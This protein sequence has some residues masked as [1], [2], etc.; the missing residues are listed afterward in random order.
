[1]KA[2]LRW[3]T[4]LLG[5]LPVFLFL[6]GG[7]P[8]HAAVAIES[9]ETRCGAISAPGQLEM[10]TF[11]GTA[12]DRV[13]I[14]AETASGFLD[15]EILLIDPDFL[16]EVDTF[17]GG[18]L[19]DHI[20]LKSGSYTI[21]VRDNGLDHTGSYCL[22]L[23]NLTAGPV[24]SGEDP[25][26][27]PIASGETRSATIALSDMDA[28][29]FDGEAGDRILIDAEAGSGFLD[30]EILL[31]DPHFLNEA[32]TYPRGDLLDHI[33]LK[34]GTYTILV[35]DH[36]LDHTGSYNITLLNL[37]A[38]PLTSSEDPDGGPIASGETR[39]A[40]IALSDMDAYQFYGEAGD[41]VVIDAETGSGF[42]DTEILLIDPHFLNEVD[43]YPGG[44]LLDHVLLETGTYTILVQDHGLDHTGGY[45]LTLLKLP[46][47][48]SSPGD[49]DGGL[50]IAGNSRTGTITLSDMDTYQFYGEAGDRVMITAVRNSGFLD[51]EILLIDPDGLDETD[52]QPGGDLLDHF[53]Q[54]TGLYSFVI[55]DVGLDHT[56]NYSMT[57][58]KF[59]QDPPPGIYQ[60]EP[61]TACN[62]STDLM[63]TWET[64]SDAT[65]YDVFFGTNVVEPLAQIAV[66]E[67]NSSW[68]VTGLEK[69]TVYYWRVVA[70]TP[71]GDVQGT[72]NWFV[73]KILCDLNHDCRC[74]MQDWLLFGQD[75]G[76]TDCNDPG[77]DPCECDL[78]GDGRCD[79]QDWLLFGRQWGWS[80][81]P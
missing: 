36:G 56:G 32:D 58:N 46:G 29:Q 8:I 19:L 51:T 64:V 63:L 41:R 47:A 14:D 79:M 71:G 39:S 59:P 38:G 53:T 16:N 69:S 66:S 54:K 44:D 40:T 10:W 80:I 48:T 11:Q 2:H 9:G 37:T 68:L 35:Q 67:P 55:Q 20:L 81:C 1:M 65:G 7:E 26:G 34:S 22:T 43:T 61:A 72:V 73:T 76:R 42:L 6:L 33:L 3:V 17:P 4:L 45:S 52:T 50:I 78:N 57:F 31:I 25:D 18:D 28:Y 74:D 23:L 15:T 62:Q 77:V 27:G 30:T 5:S 49:C 12:G 24:T 70:H 13:V 60:P 75:W 21:V